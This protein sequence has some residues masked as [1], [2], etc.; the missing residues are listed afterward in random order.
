MARTTFPL[1]SAALESA[2]YDDASQDLD[3][4]FAGGRRFTYHDVPQDVAEGL[5][6]ATSPGSFFHNRIKD[7]YS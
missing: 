6:D 5:R 3:I 7:Q 2:T 1:V 4:T